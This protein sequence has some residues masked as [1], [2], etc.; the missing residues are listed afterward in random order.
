MKAYLDCYPCFFKQAIH[1]ARNADLS[2][3]ETR[4][5]LAALGE[6]LSDFDL[7]LKPPEM[8]AVIHRLIRDRSGVEDPYLSIKRHSIGVALSLYEDLKKTVGESKDPFFTALL[9]AVIGN[10]IDFG[11]V[12]ELDIEGEI[13]KLLRR[14]MEIVRH[15]DRRFFAHQEFKE[16]LMSSS[17]LLYIG[18]NAGETVFDRILL[19][20]IKNLNSKLDIVYAVRGFPVI[21]DALFDDAVESGIDKLARII[22]NGHDAPATLLPYCSAQLREV[23]SDADMV[24]SKGQ[25]NYESLSDADRE[26]FFLLMAKCPVIA[27]DVGCRKGDVLLLRS[28]EAP[29]P[30]C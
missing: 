15:E 6:K 23:F 26:V 12:Q 20:E 17:S 14:E 3:E 25:G 29:I 18:D 8:A 22:S 11:A 7:S 16:R 28:Q 27:E 19:E 21:N 1:A 4:R 10:I 24:I 5:L 13:K 2:E 9:M 30:T